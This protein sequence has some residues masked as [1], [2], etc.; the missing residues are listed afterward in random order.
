[1]GENHNSNKRVKIST[2]GL[3]LLVALLLAG[4]GVNGVINYLK[5]D[6]NAIS[7]IWQEFQQSRSVKN[8]II[9]ALWADF[10]YGG[11][12]HNYKNYL[13]RH[14]EYYYNA[15]QRKLSSI[16]GLIAQYRLLDIS[17]KENNALYL[18]RQDVDLYKNGLQNI[19]LL[20]ET[21]TPIFE[22]D[23]KVII[24]DVPTIRGVAVLKQIYD[25]Q[26]EFTSLLIEKNKNLSQLHH[27]LGYDGMIHN[28]KNFILRNKSIDAEKTRNN[29]LIIRRILQNL[30]NL[31]LNNMELG[32]LAEI[33]NA[34]TTYS[35]A[36]D[37]AEKMARA[38]NS[39][40]EIDN[41]VQVN[42]IFALNAL[43]TLERGVSNQIEEEAMIMSERIDHSENV[44]VAVNF[45]T[46]LLGIIFIA[47]VVWI[48]KVRVIN[49]IA[50]ISELTMRL[51]QGDLSIEIDEDLRANDEIGQM[52]NSLT[53]FKKNA[54]RRREVENRLR[55]I[56]DITPQAIILID[57][58]FNIRQVNKSA[59]NI[60]GYL[61]YQIVGRSM[62]VLIPT[63][64]QKAHHTHM[65]NY[66]NITN[67]EQLHMGKRREI[68]GQRKNG[69]EFP[70]I[71]SITAMEHNGEDNFL[72]AL[73]DITK[74]KKIERK[75]QKALNQ[76]ENANKA[77]SEFM[78]NMSHELRTPLNSIIGFSEVMSSELMGPMGSYQYVE[79]AMNIHRS[80]KHLLE[81]VNDILDIERIEAGVFELNIQEYI[82]AQLTQECHKLLYKKA[83]E[84]EINF[85]VNMDNNLPVFVGDRR[86]I[87]QILINLLTNAIKFTEKDGTVD[88]NIKASKADYIFEVID[89]GIGIPKERIPKLTDPFV[90]H[91]SDPHT[92]QEG[93]GLGL[94]IAKS[95]VKLHHGN[96]TVE[97]E[98]GKG[99]KV[100]VIIPRTV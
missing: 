78:A 39:I 15:T 22:I 28:F 60:F 14:N 20:I 36:L 4:A 61:E 50:K 37:M 98:V 68:Y 66:M 35:N 83:D 92:S 19:K 16:E 5:K 63:R 93:V 46:A 94:A 62:D 84:K 95:L 58:N 86:A 71:A 100:R 26:S 90:K 7:V 2:L 85:N 3:V 80:G 21:G 25:D 40:T 10:G 48:L 57:K 13:L 88:F 82:V 18:I 27:V 72:V 51:A 76:T 91:E 54:I 52:A 11:M 64:F 1:M 69:D 87:L 32:A 17:D 23:Q 38:N 96:M 12:I 97:S 53:I 81:M 55:K 34:V 6:V 49:P 75:L 89:T 59:V 43:I 74:Q 73:V 8:E 70:A 44:M 9:T 24:H 41:K 45:I 31:R 56:L 29:F 67:S 30:K 99:T 47:C 77:K 65:A 79:Y 33:S 42:D